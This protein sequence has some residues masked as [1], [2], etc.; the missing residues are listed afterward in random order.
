MANNYFGIGS[1]YY[2]HHNPNTPIVVSNCVYAQEYS[3]MRDLSQD[4][5]E[6][7]TFNITINEEEEQIVLEQKKTNL[8]QTKQKQDEINQIQQE[9]I[10]KEEIKSDK[11]KNP[12]PPYVCYV[13]EHCCISLLILYMTIVI[14]FQLSPFGTYLI[15]QYNEQVNCIN[16]SN[17]TECINHYILPSTSGGYDN[18]CN[19][20]IC[21]SNYICTAIENTTLTDDNRSC[22]GDSPYTDM[23][24]RYQGTSYY[25]SCCNKWFP[26]DY[27]KIYYNYFCTLDTLDQSELT[28]IVDNC[29]DFDYNTLFVSASTSTLLNISLL[30]L[31]IVVIYTFVVKYRKLNILSDESKILYNLFLG[32]CI[33]LICLV[34]SWNTWEY[35]KIITNTAIILQ[36]NTQC[37]NLVNYELFEV[38]LN[39]GFALYFASVPVFVFTFAT[40]II[41]SLCSVCCLIVCCLSIIV[42]K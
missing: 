19:S 21:P 11:S 4:V 2:N 28:E 7:V 12:E 27:N 5:N 29:Y 41:S 36:Y 25:S 16:S 17:N 37:Y 39:Y 14:V 40:L 22:G 23:C 33:S 26:Y 30:I 8:K 24:K 15:N 3:S 6:G 10:I 20:D 38:L 9:K 34:I 42:G 32:I 1:S 18:D 35:Y 13:F 31:T